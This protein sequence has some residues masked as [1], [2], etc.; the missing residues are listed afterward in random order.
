MYG[1][2]C[3]FIIHLD[4]TVIKTSTQFPAKSASFVG[5]CDPETFVD[6]ACAHKPTHVHTLTRMQVPKHASTRTQMRAR[7]FNISKFNQFVIN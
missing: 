4:I 7:D 6:D 5:M 2:S 3:H 1:Y